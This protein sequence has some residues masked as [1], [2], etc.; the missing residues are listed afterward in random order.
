MARLH[1][2]SDI[3]NVY[4]RPEKLIVNSNFYD[5]RMAPTGSSLAEKLKAWITLDD[6]LTTDGKIVVC[7]V[8]E[9]KIGC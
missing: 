3:I 1:M 8:C 9:K 4:R 2:R 7:Q 5:S 6:M